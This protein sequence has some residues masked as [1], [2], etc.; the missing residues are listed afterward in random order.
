MTVP[1][2]F[3]I[4]IASGLA[5][6]SA[7]ALAGY[8]LGTIVPDYYRAVFRITPESAVN[9]A[10]VGAGLGAT[11]GIAVGLTVGLVIVIV[12]AWY[13]ARAANK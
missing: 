5:F 9:P 11:Q 8:G 4:T 2:A 3:L 12:V 13:K 10:Q 6:A 1:R 7:G